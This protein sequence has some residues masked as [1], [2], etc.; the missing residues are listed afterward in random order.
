MPRSRKDCRFP[1]VSLSYGSARQDG[2]RRATKALRLTATGCQGHDRIVDFRTRGGPCDGRRRRERFGWSRCRWASCG[3]KRPFLE[4]KKKSC[5]QGR[6]LRC[7]RTACARRGGEVFPLMIRPAG[8]GGRTC[9]KQNLFHPRMIRP[10][11][12]GGACLRSNTRDNCCRR[13]RGSGGWSIRFQWLAP[14]LRPRL[15]AAAASRL[16][17][18]PRAGGPKGHRPLQG[19][20]S[21]S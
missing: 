4:Q 5:Q 2:G 18:S 10:V 14:G 8:G 16:N 17:W 19:E 20:A 9:L 1:I 21:N 6:A 15:H 11:V 13:L 12:W 3:G 7:R